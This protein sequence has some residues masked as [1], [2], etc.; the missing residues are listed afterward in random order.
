MR[1]NGVDELEYRVRDEAL[2]SIGEL[3]S[4]VRGTELPPLEGNG[5]N[6]QVTSAYKD[7][8]ISCL[9]DALGVGP[10]LFYIRRMRIWKTPA[11]VGTTNEPVEVWEFVVATDRADYPPS[12]WLQKHNNKTLRL[13][14]TVPTGSKDD[15]DY[16][17]LGLTQIKLVDTQEG[18]KWHSH[19]GAKP[20]RIPLLVRL[21]SMPRPTHGIPPRLLEHVSLKPFSPAPRT[22]FTPTSTAQETLQQCAT[23]LEVQKRVSKSTQ[24]CVAY[25]GLSKKT[26]NSV[27]LTDITVDS[28]LYAPD[29]GEHLKESD[30]WTNVKRAE[31]EEVKLYKAFD[32]GSQ[33]YSTYLIG[34]VGSI[35]GY[36]QKERTITLE[37]DEPWVK[38]LER[39]EKQLPQQGV[40]W[41]EAV[42]DIAQIKRQD[43]ALEKLKKGWSQNPELCNLLF[44]PQ[45]IGT[46]HRSTPLPEIGQWLREDANH[47][48]KQA[49]QTAIFCPGVALL[50]GPPGTGKTT[51]IAEICYQVALRGGRA[52]VTSQ[53]H[54]AVDNALSRLK[55]S[56]EIR[57]IRDGKIDEDVV[58]QKR[59]SA[60]EATKAWLQS[61]ASKSKEQLDTENANLEGLGE[62]LAARGEFAD[63]LQLEEQLATDGDLQAIH[64]SKAEK[65]KAC[66]TARRDF[67]AVQRK[68]DAFEE[69]QRSVEHMLAA[70]VDW[71][72]SDL[73][74]LLARL[75]P[76]MEHDQEWQAYCQA[77][78]SILQ[79]I[80]VLP[81]E[82]RDDQHPLI[83]AAW[84]YGQV[85][86]RLQ[87]I[88]H[89]VNL[90]Q[91]TTQPIEAY[92]A[93]LEEVQCRLTATQQ[94]RR[95]RQEI[96]HRLDDLN[97][98]LTRE[99]H[100]QEQLAR[101]QQYS[102][103]WWTGLESQVATIVE[104]LV[105]ARNLI[106]DDYMRQL[107][108]AWPGTPTAKP[109][110]DQA[111]THLR[112]DIATSVQ[113]AL[114]HDRIAQISDKV[115][116]E[117]N[118]LRA[119]VGDKEV[120]EDTQAAAERKISPL[121]GD[122]NALFAACEAEDTSR[123][124]LLLGKTDYYLRKLAHENAVLCMLRTAA[125]PYADDATGR[126]AGR[127]AAAT[128]YTLQQALAST[129][130]QRLHR[131]QEHR[132]A[133]AA[134]EAN[135]QNASIN[136]ETA[137]QASSIAKKAMTDAE[138]AVREVLSQF[139][140]D[141]FVPDAIKLAVSEFRRSPTDV[142]ARGHA[143][144]C[145][146][147]EWL[148]N[149]RT[150]DH[151]LQT[152]PEPTMVLRRA[153]T[154]LAY[155]RNSLRDD[156]DNARRVWGRSQQALDEVD[157]ELE[158]HLIHV[159]PRQDEWRGILD[160]LPDRYKELLHISGD[161]TDLAILRRVDDCLETWQRMYDSSQEF[162]DHYK[163]YMAEW[164]AS[165]SLAVSDDTQMS[166]IEKL[167]LQHINVVGVTCNQAD[168]RSR[169][170][171]L[172]QV[173]GHFDIVII[174]EVSKCTPP[175]IV[176]PALLADRII[177][178]GDHRQLPAI[179]D[180][181]LLDEVVDK[182]NL[183]DKDLFLRESL[184][185]QLYDA[186]ELS[187]NGRREFSGITH[188]LTTQY[189]MH[190]SI[191]E[192]I[193]QFYLPDN[194]P[195][196][197]RKTTC[198][199]HGLA[200]SGGLRCGLTNCDKGSQNR[201]HNLSLPDI[202]RDAPDAVLHWLDHH[203][204][205]I[206]LPRATTGNSAYHDKKF[207]TSY[208]NEAE[209]GIVEELCRQ[210][211]HA[212]SERLEEQAKEQETVSGEMQSFEGDAPIK[213]EVAVITF[214]GAQKRHLRTLL[215]PKSG[216]FKALDV[217]VDTVDRFQGAEA[218]VVI[219]SLVRNNTFGT[220]GFA[221]K[222]ERINVAF[223][224]AQQLL[225]IVGC[226][227]MFERAGGGSYAKIRD[228]VWAYD[229]RIP[230]GDFL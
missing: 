178:V 76:V 81:F 7:Y 202:V 25:G 222:P 13:E 228:V 4:E 36:K 153:T 75:T 135:L 165:V 221:T 5:G 26:I 53:T 39:K 33:D 51:V 130:A 84:I 93:A 143:L 108:D 12:V 120:G 11:T 123:P 163:E 125:Q 124:P 208:Y 109:L 147:D 15:R 158:Q 227:E 139:T 152:L 121:Q 59:F 188:M 164:I 211:E 63:Y 171:Q 182:L 106:S 156:V 61:C 151:E 94:A 45:V 157:A 116:R 35:K 113:H 176:I 185:K 111:L 89:T 48:Q 167:Y 46:L 119:K 105:R 136:I 170:D 41:F 168:P 201:M 34:K 29:G 219:V 220:V 174:D 40:L 104:T 159:Q 49:V 27:V 47:E 223:S 200:P 207:G 79:H 14:A 126:S 172:A 28:A 140:Q 218:P 24:F 99:I 20:Y 195:F 187:A 144:R 191:M 66:A 95:M 101:G 162:L 80:T 97:A 114:L 3:Y 74:T 6:S 213:K 107:Q 86:P 69:M 229:G 83:D 145:L 209:I 142:A 194:I 38:A 43:N 57:A 112:Q 230:N 70:A 62:I 134:L 226:R 118:D 128:V 190:H 9:T 155:G 18:V 129:V 183:P 42:G 23:L 179:I 32:L 198:E 54:V 181:E 31:G 52:L 21:V 78:T 115:E 127:I 85:L 146:I 100:E 96:Q 88:R 19:F 141:K 17:G 203:I 82:Q 64:R 148:A 50:Q 10:C 212:W 71:N 224:R 44:D 8:A 192:A 55:D 117:Q 160:R 30:L 150:L 91:V 137:I 77:V 98:T 215:T 73:A 184:F 102:N 1:V 72:A 2:R 196:T 161:P 103:Q 189:R 133:A 138:Q 131:M 166:Q 173:Y 22:I 206:E 210:M 214:Y 92:E 217:R 56:P 225:I 132:D 193:N 216:R 68:I 177:L 58:E 110:W 16:S 67:D 197:I 37:L 87:D 204:V 175:E 122:I 154:L 90:G 186:A 60:P 180:D 205:W 169:N 149:M 199:E 65:A